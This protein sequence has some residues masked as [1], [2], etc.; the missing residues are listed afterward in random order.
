M[1]ECALDVVG[2]SVA[3]GLGLLKSSALF[4]LLGLVEISEPTFSTFSAGMVSRP[5]GDASG[6]TSYSS[7]VP[8]SKRAARF[9]GFNCKEI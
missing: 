3:R 1:S 8:I 7:T 6:C 4:K 5:F 2:L 9:F